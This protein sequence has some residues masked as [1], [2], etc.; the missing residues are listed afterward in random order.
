MADYIRGIGRH[1]V[2]LLPGASELFCLLFADD[3]ALISTTPKGLQCQLDS[4]SIS[5]HHLGLNVNRV[6]TRVMVFRKGGFLGKGERWTTDGQKLEVVNQ[7][8]Y[9]GFVFT[10]N[11]SLSA[12]LHNQVVGAKRRTL[13]LL[14]TMKNL[15]TQSATVFFKLYDTQILPTLLYASPVWG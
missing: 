10:I 6:K 2:H 1:G 15:H 11:L 3:I 7:Y 9:L 5:S 8:E 13:H 14:R 4:L 12:A